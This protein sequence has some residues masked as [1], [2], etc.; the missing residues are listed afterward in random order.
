MSACANRAS[1][2]LTPQ[3]KTVW[4]EYVRETVNGPEVAVG[5]KCLK[6]K[7]A[8]EDHFAAFMDW[9]YYCTWINTDKGQEPYAKA[10]AA[11]AVEREGVEDNDAYKMLHVGMRVERLFILKNEKEFEDYFDKKPKGPMPAVPII[12]A[13]NELTGKLEAARC[14]K[15]DGSEP[16]RTDDRR[17]TVFAEVSSVEALHKMHAANTIFAGQADLAFD[18][19]VNQNMSD[20]SLSL[21]YGYNKVPSLREFHQKFS[22]ET[23]DKCYVRETAAPAQPAQ[24]PPRVSASTP[25]KSTSCPFGELISTA[26]SP[27]VPATGQADDAECGETDGE[28]QLDETF[29]LWN[30]FPHES[31][32][33]SDTQTVIENVSVVGADLLKAERAGPAALLDHLKGRVPCDMVL[34][35]VN[36][37]RQLANIEYYVTNGKLQ[38]PYVGFLRSFIKVATSCK[39]LDRKKILDPNA[40]PLIEVNAH[41]ANLAAAGVPL[42]PC[43]KVAL[44]QRRIIDWT[45]GA[46]LSHG[47]A[48][49]VVESAKVWANP[50]D[51]DHLGIQQF[52]TKSPAV[53]AIREF[54]A[55][56]RLALA[57]HMLV[58]K[59]LC[60]Y[61]SGG[62]S[63]EGHAINFCVAM[64]AHIEE[65]TPAD[66]SPVA[67]DALCQLCSCCRALRSVLTYDDATIV[68]DGVDDVRALV[69]SKTLAKATIVNTVAAAVAGNPFFNGKFGVFDT[70][71]GV[72]AE[73]MPK[74]DAAQKELASGPRSVDEA[75]T[76]LRELCERVELFNGVGLEQYLVPLL[77]SMKA[78]TLAF[79]K[80]LTASPPE[81]RSK[82]R[83]ADAIRVIGSMS[84]IIPGDED[85]DAISSDAACLQGNLLASSLTQEVNKVVERVA[86]LAEGSEKFRE[87][88]TSVKADLEQFDGHV[89]RTKE[90]IA[91]AR[92]AFSHCVTLAASLVA[93]DCD[94]AD[95]V[96]SLAE[97]LNLMCPVQ[98]SAAAILNLVK[99]LR[100]MVCSLRG[101]QKLDADVSNR[102]ALDTPSSPNGWPHLR[103]L[104]QRLQS[105]LRARSAVSEEDLL[106]GD[107]VVDTYIEEAQACVTDASERA[108]FE[109]EEKLDAATVAIQAL[110]NA[111]GVATYNK[112]SAKAD[113]AELLLH[114]EG[115]L[116]RTSCDDLEAGQKSLEVATSIAT[117]VFDRFGVT[118]PEHKTTTSEEVLAQ[119]RVH[120]VTHK[121]LTHFSTIKTDKGKLRTSVMD[122]V[123]LSSQWKVSKQIDDRILLR[124]EQAKK[125][126]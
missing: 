75:C 10:L 35:G 122:A 51:D 112:Y 33:V 82:D 20:A 18:S 100:D 47:D 42:Q 29:V 37:N 63:K 46:E 23:Y 60:T 5:D 3:E 93:R 32:Q 91:D 104:Q 30:E 38:E 53:F 62:E 86:Y 2:T 113:F 114:A 126:R 83:V 21:L 72:I 22:P 26:G 107:V 78:A 12:Q 117:A 41:L 61:V 40:L 15:V 96:A 68:L 71:M 48:M 64:L 56:Y 59:V 14:W 39:E 123:K 13:P 89:L 97:T 95:T 11:D 58:E 94:S 101:Y 85:L 81:T 124:V 4:A 44:W 43:T 49:R 106:S 77:K 65:D 76:Q 109:A 102:L 120:V 92:R 8:Y 87:E 88:L 125:F 19:S 54:D 98:P 57:M 17:L 73:H 84:S 7:N 115:T 16:L 31:V 74:I 1:H 55:E 45:S 36:K 66:L 27:R 52:D 116:L 24:T 79:W 34:N 121:I 108:T 70:N 119:S 80:D 105:V 6:D 99:A 69:A 118:M 28:N 25:T 67:T 110:L 103:G 90:E 111:D 50:G 9:P